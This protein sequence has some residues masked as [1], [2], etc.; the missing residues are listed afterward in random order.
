M[1]RMIKAW[2]VPWGSR[3]LRP[4]APHADRKE[5]GEPDQVRARVCLQAR[6]W[7]LAPDNPLA[8]ETASDVLRA[9]ESQAPLV[10]GWDSGLM[11]CRLYRWIGAWDASWL[12]VR[13]EGA[14]DVVTQSQ[15]A[16]GARYD[17]VGIVGNKAATPVDCV[18]PPSPCLPGLRVNQ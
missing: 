12:K 5:A 13:K 3:A 18:H 17:G 15:S 9:T 6:D 11:V 16:G 1:H 8:Q 14:E 4:L 10:G 7:G 2:Y